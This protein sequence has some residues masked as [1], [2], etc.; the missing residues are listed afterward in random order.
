MAHCF[1][2][3]NTIPANILKSGIKKILDGLAGMKYMFWNFALEM[4]GTL[5][6]NGQELEQKTTDS[7]PVPALECIATSLEQVSLHHNATAKLCL[8]L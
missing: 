5:S 6:K 7:S 8:S 2:R 4:L 3:L 1:P